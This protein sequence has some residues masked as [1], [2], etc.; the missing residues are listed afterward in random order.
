[1]LT[2]RAESRGHQRK[3]SNLLDI[4]KDLSGKYDKPPP[5]DYEAAQTKR[6]MAA[7]GDYSGDIT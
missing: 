1:L 7:S 5:A 2:S 6:K 3:C 4:V